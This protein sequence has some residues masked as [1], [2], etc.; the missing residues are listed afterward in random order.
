MDK[1]SGHGGDFEIV[2]GERVRKGKAPEAVP[3]GGGARDSE[4]KRIVE[5]APAK[6]EPAVPAPAQRAPWDAPAAAPA[7]VQTKKKGA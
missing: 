6:P 3:E 5:A 7:E 1:H 4:G 2:N